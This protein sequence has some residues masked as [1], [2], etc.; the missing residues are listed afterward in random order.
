MQTGLSITSLLTHLGQGAANLFDSA[1]RWVGLEK[2][3]LG[4]LNLSLSSVPR[5][6][7][8]AEI[9]NDVAHDVQPAREAQATNDT[10][11]QASQAK[12][13]RG[14]W[15][16]NEQ[17][18]I[19]HNNMYLVFS[20]LM[21]T[22]FLAA[23]DQTIVA[24][25]LPTI[26]EELGGGNDYSWVGS[27]YLLAASALSPLYGKLSDIM[28]RKPVLYSCILIFLIGSALCGA[29][30]TMTW[31][32]V[33]RA[34]QGI[35]GG[36][37]IQMVQI[38]IS[39]IVPLENV[40]GP[41]M[42]GALTD[43]VTWRWCFWINLPTGGLAA[44]ILF[45][46]LNLNPHQG[47][48]LREHAAQF[49]FIGLVLLVGGVVCLLI[50]FNNSDNGWGKPATIVLL[51]VGVVLL[52]AASINELFTKR[53][54]ILPPRLFKTRTT[55]KS[56]ELTIQYVRMLPF[57]L[58]AAG[59]SAFQGLLVTKLG[60][61]RGIIWF[62]WTVMTLGFGLMIQLTDTTS[63]ALKAVY[64]LIAAIGVGGLFQTPLI[65]LQASMPLKDMATSTAAMVLIRTLGG[66]IG[67]SVGQAIWSSELVKRLPSI[68]GF[69]ADTS[70]GALAQSV[71]SLKN[72]QPA[73]VRQQV[74]HAY[75]KSIST[76]WLVDTPILFVGLV[77][78][79]FILKYTLKRTIIRSEK[80]GLTGDGTN[81]G[82]TATNASSNG[83]AS[84]IQPERDLEKGVEGQSVENHEN[85]VDDESD[86]RDSSSG[87]DKSAV[88]DEKQ[89]QQQ[90]PVE[91]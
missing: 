91:P 55:N 71:P 61:Y 67:I 44:V 47:R 50:G 53:S 69:H 1:P 41:L 78:S 82:T 39:D 88:P 28:G 33:C 21:M 57:S 72:I 27:A 68:S 7:F 11:T 46:F 51:V 83:T 45:V 89:Q 15:K 42:G 34:V 43:H 19:P 64:P 32:I 8:M 26:V 17:Q 12:K 13:E 10:M 14:A 66:T 37:I 31:L 90:Q 75:A 73:S 2:G 40:I 62:S 80:P 54:P 22:T 85:E 49:D 30:Q 52:I 65:A 84:Q 25:A 79:L 63:N 56:H 16:A 60:D 20:G 70:P 87:D 23:L 18:T 35:G 24:T 6:S 29:A 86:I 81:P 9:D 58:G 3:T 76:I 5:P 48:T 4:F 36:G 38:T 77:M 74:I 59:V